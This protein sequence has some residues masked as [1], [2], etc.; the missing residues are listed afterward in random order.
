MKL[1]LT[2]LALAGAAT[3]ATAQAQLTWS[4]GVLD[5]YWEQQLEWPA[6][7]AGPLWFFLPSL[8]AGPTPLSLLDPTDPRELQIGLDLYPLL[9]QE[10]P[11]IGQGT[12]LALGLPAVPALVGSTLHAQ[13]FT[14]PGATTVVDQVSNPVRNRL[15][16]PGETWLAPG[17]V[18]KPRREHSLT[19]LADGRVLVFGGDSPAGGA[20]LQVEVYDPQMQG[21][22][23]AGSSIVPRTRHAAVQL[24]SGKVLIVGGVGA[25]GTAL[26]SCQL[27]DPAT[28]T[29][30]PAASMS[31]P[32]VFHALVRLGDGRVL[33]AGGSMT[34]TGGDPIGYP[35]VFSGPMASSIEVYDPVGNS[36]STPASFPTGRMGMAATLQANGK[37]LLTGGVAK[38]GPSGAA[39]TARTFIFDPN[40][41]TLENGVDLPK[42]LALHLQ[43]TTASGKTLVTG[44]GRFKF[45]PV[46]YTGSKS[47]FLIGPQESSWAIAPDLNNL[48]ACTDIV[49]VPKPPDKRLRVPV[50]V[51]DQSGPIWDWGA[52]D[53][54]YFA[55]G[56]AGSIAF[57]GGSSVV[58]PN[59]TY[60]RI[61][62]T[63]S[64]WDEPAV[65]IF[66]RPGSR[67]A[68]TDEG[69]RLLVVGAPLDAPGNGAS[70][71]LLTL[72]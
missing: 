29:T 47:T 18:I 62:D 30:A 13:F 42:P 71:E 28:G 22:E 60:L 67:F 56:G 12:S 35:A 34:F 49:C 57:V 7:P 55:G 24:A 69:R 26:S 27:Y 17:E 65:Q 68:A 21:F 70:A 14:V 40:G 5:G 53:I 64:A 46:A 9:L 36:W 72:P 63:F 11:L 20:V 4:Q 3:T 37:V 39:T 16:S 44:G 45:S 66:T 59:S 48:V 33:V 25:G 58:T 54:S 43:I 51:P 61:F 8:N 19:P 15:T 32:R 1:L 31:V 2:A 6:G 38:T 41:D 50:G 10:G 52:G 23:P